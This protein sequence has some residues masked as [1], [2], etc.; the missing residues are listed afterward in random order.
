MPSDASEEEKELAQSLCSIEED[1]Y[2][3]IDLEFPN[4]SEE[5]LHVDATSFRLRI[6]VGTKYEKLGS[7]PPVADG[8]LRVKNA[9][10]NG[11]WEAA[12]KEIQVQHD[13]FSTAPEAALAVA[14]QEAAKAGGEA[15]K[16]DKTGGGA[17][18]LVAP[19]V[20]AA[21]AA[22]GLTLLLSDSA[23]GFK[24]VFAS[25]KRG[26][27][28]Y[29]QW[30]LLRTA[31]RTNNYLGTFSTAPEAA[32]AVA[33][34]E[35]ALAAA[36]QEAAKEGGE[37]V[38]EAAHASEA[39]EA[40]EEGGEEAAAE[41]AGEE[42]GEVAEPMDEEGE[43]EGA[44]EEVVA[45]THP[46][47]KRQKHTH[48]V[49]EATKEEIAAKLEMR[50]AAAAD[51]SVAAAS[52]D[53]PSPV[54]MPVKRVCFNPDLNVVA[55][56]ATE[57]GLPMDA[58]DRDQPDSDQPASPQVGTANIPLLQEEEEEE[59]E[60]E[61]VEEEVEDGCSSASQAGGAESTPEPGGADGVGGMDVEGLW[62]AE[63]EAR[64]RRSSVGVGEVAA[65][66]GDA[67]QSG[68]TLHSPRQLLDAVHQAVRRKLPLLGPCRRGLAQAPFMV[69]PR[70]RLGG[71]HVGSRLTVC[72]VYADAGFRLLESGCQGAGAPA[73][74]PKPSWW[75]S[76]GCP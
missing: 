14:R 72:S 6:F 58:T 29:A 74:P 38:P 47:M 59:A 63:G 32:L 65:A 56:G 76:H 18:E 5:R 52:A 37:A 48:I 70:V 1:G 8:A 34:K 40:G 44:T 46:P 25:G 41:A 35:A 11:G 67:P 53:A 28:F 23:T 7:I 12:A 33:R 19:E 75:G 39:K 4:S 61:K 27:R 66:A 3:R 26:S 45:N 50:E 10:K 9:F 64:H 2:M 31:E 21:A 51:A 16:A 60:E 55:G 57:Y 36:R 73:R 15:M 17:A 22:E 20:H 42:A 24:G 71:Q 62:A 69:R 30:P 49:A 68:S 43:H 54:K 13:A